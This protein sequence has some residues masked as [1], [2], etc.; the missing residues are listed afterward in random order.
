MCDSQTN[1]HTLPVAVITAAT[2]AAIESKIL[3][4]PRLRQIPNLLLQILNLE[5]IFLT[6]VTCMKV[7]AL[8][9]VNKFYTYQYQRRFR[10]EPR[11]DPATF[12]G[13]E[14][15]GPPLPTTGLREDILPH[16]SATN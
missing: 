16:D 10:T 8:E 7:G 12:A 6:I 9:K 11:G 14:D 13:G 4:F 5:S 15:R 2:H 1:P 3:T